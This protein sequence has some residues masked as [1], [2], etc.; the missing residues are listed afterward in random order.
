[1]GR[2]CVHVVLDPFARAEL[3]EAFDAEQ[4]VRLRVRLG[5]VRLAC[6]GQYRLDEI[7][8]IEGCSRASV[9]NW[10]ATF[11]TGGLSALLMRGKPGA[12]ASPMHDPAVQ[13]RLTDMI[14]SGA[15]R[16]GTQAQEWL[17][18]TLGIH[19]SL[20]GVYY[21]LK[22][23]G[24]ALRVPRPVHIKKDPQATVTFLATLEQRL[25][26][27]PLR[28][29][30]PVRIWV[31]DE[32]RFGL[33]TLVRRCWARRGRRVVLPAVRKY[34]WHYL[35]SALEI[36][37]GRIHNV[38]MP[39]VDLGITTSFLTSLAAAEPDADHI[40]LWDGAG[41]H[42]RPEL[43]PVPEN[44]HILRLP[45][46]SPELNPV[47]KL[48]DVI[49]DG[50]CN[51]IFPTLDDLLAAIAPELEPFL[52]PQRVLQLLGRSPMLALANASSKI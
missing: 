9:A 11:R 7:A 47:E 15:F 27:L 14:D 28:P 37:T 34:Q 38:W 5:V 46:Y 24:A 26:E 40:I 42:P 35:Y 23:F 41:F 36:V 18:A 13:Q 43:H 29:G 51:R 52:H 10:L 8:E 6:S 22:S 4:D 33:H 31:E 45:P 32:A 17:A 44:V 19:L 30:R 16:T 3:E 2:P 50:L 12:C 48:W 49:K 1:M 39:G 21:W 25:T 20:T